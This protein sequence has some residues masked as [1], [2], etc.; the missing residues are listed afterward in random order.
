MLGVVYFSPMK[1][2][3]LLSNSIAQFRLVAWL[4]GWS[5][6]LLL[7]VAMPIKYGLGEPLFVRILGSAHGALFVMYLLSLY[8]N[9]TE[10]NWHTGQVL[11]AALM[12]ILPFGTFYVV[13]KQWQKLTGTAKH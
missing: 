1:F 6:V 11:V 2:K 3:T 12:S 4:E 13:G 8:R 10:H 5:F 9:K 7:F